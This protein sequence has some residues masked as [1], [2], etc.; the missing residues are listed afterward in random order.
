MKDVKIC[1]VIKKGKKKEREKEKV[2][3]YINIQFRAH[4]VKTID[5]SSTSLMLK[6][7][8]EIPLMNVL[9]HFGILLN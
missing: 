3:K 1:L 8:R 6:R 4:N 9:N 2:H 7:S 5:G